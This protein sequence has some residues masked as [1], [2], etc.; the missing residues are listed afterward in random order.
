[1]DLFGVYVPMI[2]PLTADDTVDVPALHAHIDFLI[3]SGVHGLIPV[4]STGESQSLRPDE[5][6]RVIR[7]TVEHVNRRV[8]V[9][10]GTSANSTEQTIEKCRY[11]MSVGADGFMITHP[12]YSQPDQHELYEHYARIAESVDRPIMIYNN[13]VTTG[14][15]SQPDLLA[16]LSQFKTVRY[17]KESTNDCTRIVRILE[18]SGDRLKVFSGTDNLALEHFSSG[19]SGWVAGAANVLP[20][21][22]VKLY[23][24]AVEK[25]DFVAA[26]AVYRQIYDYLTVCEATGKFVQ[27]AKAGVEI[28]GGTAGPPRRPLLPLD[29]D[30]LVKTRQAIEK[31]QHV[32]I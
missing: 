29:G 10:A 1:M 21:E 5:C 20:R 26:L 30:L 12:F 13:P 8:P 27:V 15:D 22:C 25:R 17:V 11:A 31:A 28:I 16:R 14:V 7:E 6:E 19:A 3:S 9:L 18:A 32:P 2:T 23:T 4:G 24:L